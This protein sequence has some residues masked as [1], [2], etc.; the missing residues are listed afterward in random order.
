[1][2]GTVTSRINNRLSFIFINLI[3]LF[4]RTRN[5]EINKKKLYLNILE[6]YDQIIYLIF[7][8]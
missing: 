6:N 7:E 1:M 8:M 5:K 3:Y 2:V 4:I